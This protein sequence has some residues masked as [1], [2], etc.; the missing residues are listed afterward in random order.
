[1]TSTTAHACSAARHARVA[2]LVIVVEQSGL[3]DADLSVCYSADNCGSDP[4][5]GAGIQADLKTFAAFGV[6]GASAITAITVQSTRGVE[7]VDAARAD[8]VTA[9]I[10]AVAGDSRDRRHQDRHARHGG[11]RRSRGRGDQGAR[12]A[13]RGRRPVLVS[14]SG[15]AARRRR[16]A[17]LCSEL[18]PLRAS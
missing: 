13:A 1:V 17:A 9:Q 10:E 8:L 12:A 11:D 15:T 16:R 5:G 2:R 4:S 14:T 7:S 3:H 6:Y 18:L